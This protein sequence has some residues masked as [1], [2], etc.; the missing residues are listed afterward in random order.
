[1]I[2]KPNQA[3]EEA[4]EEEKIETG[5]EREKKKRLSQAQ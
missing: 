1:M 3:Q 2:N 4:K 5:R